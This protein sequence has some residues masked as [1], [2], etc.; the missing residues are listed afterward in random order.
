[1]QKEYASDASL[2]TRQRTHAL[3][4]VPKVNFTEWVLDR[5]A[6]RGDE[7]VLDVGMGPGTYFEALQTR[8]PRGQIVG[9]DLSLGMVRKAARHAFRG[10]AVLFNGDVQTLPF[11]A[12]TFDVVLANHMMYHVPDIAHA[13]NEIHRV[14]K[15][16]G[17]LIAATNSQFNMLEF[18]QLMAR[19]YG[20]LGAV[21]TSD[22]ALSQISQRFEL[23]NGPVHLHRHFFAVVRYDLPSALVFSEAQ[24]A[25]DYID[26]TRALEEPLLPHRVAWEDLISVLSDQIQRLINHFGELV[27]NKLSGVLIATDSGGFVQDYVARMEDTQSNTRVL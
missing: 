3:Y 15:P 22:A 17:I 24:P 12:H 8:V 1:M 25:V 6:W 27:V 11:P 7:R 19:A 14:L 20:L 10:S 9:G 26:S 21:S 4:S 16:N 23:E 18:D 5:V 2:A 13:L